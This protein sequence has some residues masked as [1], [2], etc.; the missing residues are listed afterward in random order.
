[1]TNFQRVVALVFAVVLIAAL[2]F[3]GYQEQGEI[4]DGVMMVFT[5]L[6]VLY[7]TEKWS[8]WTQRKWGHGEN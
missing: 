8:Q 5:F 7:V 4:R 3:T 1:M 6:G 2:F